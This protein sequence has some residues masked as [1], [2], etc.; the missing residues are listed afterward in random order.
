MK[1]IPNIITLSPNELPQSW[2]N[3]QA[4][5]PTPVEPLRH[6]ATGEALPPEAMGALFS[7]DAVL[8]GPGFRFE[9][10]DRIRLIPRELER[11]SKTYHTILNFQFHLSGDD[12]TGEVY[13]MAHHLTPLGEGRSSDLVMYITYLDRYR[14]AG[15]A[16]Q[17]THR[18]VVIEFT[19]TRTVESVVATRS[20]VRGDEL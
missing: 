5:M 11:Y 15:D 9:T 8:E 12:A 3:I 17:F 19:E 18:R 1:K 7:P 16:W 4:D 13:S 10:A 14:R 20:N 6:P 2:Y